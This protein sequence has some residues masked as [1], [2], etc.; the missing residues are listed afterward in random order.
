M[1]PWLFSVSMDGVVRE[2]NMLGS[3]GKAG[4]AKRE[5]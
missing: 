2:V 5:W 1:S 4:V 3:L